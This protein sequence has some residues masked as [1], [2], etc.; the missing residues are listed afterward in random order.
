[1]EES[2]HSAGGKVKIK[3]ADG[4]V[5]SAVFSD[6]GKYRYRLVRRWERLGQL[7]LFVMQNPSTA[8]ENHNDPTVAKCCRYAK[9]WGYSGVMIGNVYGYRATNN[10]ELTRHHFNRDN[11]QHVSD[12]AKQAH[13]VVLASGNPPNGLEMDYEMMHLCI[14]KDLE[15]AGQSC[16]LFYL[17]K[18][19]SGYFGHPL[20]LKGELWPTSFATEAD[21][22]E[23]K[24]FC[25]SL[26]TGGFPIEPEAFK[27]QTIKWSNIQDPNKWEL[28]PLNVLT[29]KTEEDC[30]NFCKQYLTSN[31][32]PDKI[33]L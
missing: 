6:C 29:F 13:I 24:E 31:R 30:N 33:V 9:R 3:V 11:I 25:D 1:M 5:S 16:K 22:D 28:D 8:D 23:S 17:K 32:I 18:N 21:Q 19:N 4:V 26:S 7:V 10:K 20:Y 27:P 15:A 2:K 14:M 12:M